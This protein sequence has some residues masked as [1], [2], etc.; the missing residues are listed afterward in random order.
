M[1]IGQLNIRS[2]NN[3]K[4]EVIDILNR[5]SIHV[6]CL[7]ETWIKDINFELTNQ[8]KIYLKNRADGYGGVAIVIKN[9]IISNELI[10][11]LFND[12]EIIGVKVDINNHTYNIINIYIN[13]RVNNESLINELDSLTSILG[14]MTNIIFCGD[15]NAAH[16]SWDNNCVTAN[17][18]ADLI[19]DFLSENYLITLNNGQPTH[20]NANSRAIDITATTTNIFDQFTWEILDDNCG[21]DHLLIISKQVDYQEDNKTKLITNY[22]NVITELNNLEPDTINRISDIHTINSLIENTIFN[23][24]RN[25]KKKTKKNRN[26]GGI[27]S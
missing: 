5:K 1:I 4:S 3:K 27:R 6:L 11:P 7:Q 17:N 10:L 22:R 26:H 24:T 12:I 16:P 9:R 2:I 13:P 15:I 20:I 18:R 14:T 25:I 8:H 19:Y 21:S 23:N